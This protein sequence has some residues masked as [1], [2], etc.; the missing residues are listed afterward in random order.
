MFR[1]V[2]IANRGEIAVRI[3]R[4]CRELGI[5][6]VA[7]FSDVDRS[8]R[9]VRY[10]D[11]AFP[12]GA[13][14]A[15]ESYL[16]QERIVEAALQAGAEASHP[17]YGFLAENADFTRAVQAAGL[18]FVGPHPETTALLGDK[19]AARKMASSAGIPIVPGV[20]QTINSVEE[21]TGVAEQ[22]GY[23]LLI[24]AA[25]GGGGKG[26][27]IARTP[28]ELPEAVRA[29]RSE[30]QSAFGDG[31]I[32]IEKYLERPR[33][34]VIQV[35]TDSHGTV[36]HLGERE[37]SIQR[38]HQKVVEEAPSPIVDP[39]LRAAMG[40][41]AVRAAMAAGYLNA[42]TVEFL[43]DGQRNFYFLEVNT[44]LQVEHPVTEMVTGIDLVKEQLRVAAGLPLTFRQEEV[45]WH[46]AAIE[47]RIYAEDPYNDFLPSTG[48]V[49]SYREPAGPGVRVDSGIGQGDQISIHYDPLIAKLVVWGQTRAEA[50]ARM[51]RAL[52]ECTI[53]GVRTT[54]PFHLAVMANPRFVEG[55]LS[56]HF[57]QE[58]FA[59]QKAEPAPADRQLL[60]AMASLACMLESQRQVSPRP[61]DSASPR[62]GAW[63]IAGRRRALETY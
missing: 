56:T 63:K 10:A 17:G 24:K 20:E 38:R 61:S 37:C 57:I 58:E 49:S 52:S 25:A 5:E 59:K 28:A 31:R 54:I 55:R 19:I 36:C 39:E 62:M 30:S 11:Y 3:M 26:M 6:T 8:A 35:I 13:G 50:I 47:C 48:T 27:R 60:A 51:R 18:V 12:I 41:A 21:A 46:G 2:L 22:V 33:H 44:R 14:P 34:V 4:A 42:G 32:Y 9:H 16:C 23:P 53:M 40:Q 43:L 7:I 29:A 45:R 15:T 1:R